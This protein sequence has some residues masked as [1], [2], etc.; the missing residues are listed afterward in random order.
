[1][2]LLFF[3][4]SV[5]EFSA[6]LTACVDHPFLM[7]GGIRW[8]PRHVR[9]IRRRARD[10]F[11][12]EIQGGKANMAEMVTAYDSTE[13]MQV[14][15]NV[16]ASGEGQITIGVYEA[17]SE[18]DSVEMVRLFSMNVGEAKRFAELLLAI[19]DEEIAA[20]ELEE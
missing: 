11:L 14:A 12:D 10:R 19:E 2:G 13:N 4:S 18:N 6:F 1:M 17:P 15:I 8:Y 7:T 3:M 16:K 9:E 20:S 5:I